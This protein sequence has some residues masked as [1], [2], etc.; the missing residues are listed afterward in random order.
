MTE[1]FWKPH[2]MTAYALDHYLYF[3]EDHDLEESE[4]T[5]FSPVDA[6]DVRQLVERGYLES[7][8][9][10]SHQGWHHQLYHEDG[11]WRG[12]MWDGPSGEER[13]YVANWN[14]WEQ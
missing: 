2:T 11:K 14:E 8:E 9:V 13:R 7:G 3:D 5:E 10:F 1:D 12:S 6:A 4:M